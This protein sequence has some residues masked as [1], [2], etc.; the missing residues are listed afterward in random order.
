M[1]ANHTHRI[2]RYI[3]KNPLPQFDD[4][5][6][7]IAIQD[8]L[9][10][11][12]CVFLPWILYLC[13]M[14]KNKYTH[15]ASAPSVKR[16]ERERE[17]LRERKRER[18]QNMSCYLSSIF[19]STENVCTYKTHTYTHIAHTQAKMINNTE[20]NGIRFTVC[21][22]EYA[23]EKKN[24]KGRKIEREREKKIEK[25]SCVWIWISVR[26]HVRN[27]WRVQASLSTHEYQFSI[28]EFN[29]C[30]T[31]EWW[32]NV[33]CGCGTEHMMMRNR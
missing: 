19:E 12:E 11:A 31:C 33:W 1:P 17:N 8:Q 16:R 2:Y 21:T 15:M 20:L 32:M 30:A 9:L 22:V 29:Q 10:P 26:R 24:A 18:K 4:H 25:Y 14:S 27:G 28:N 7:L 5:R 13:R 3:V 23:T 6:K